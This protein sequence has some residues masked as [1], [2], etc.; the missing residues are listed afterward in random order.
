MNDVRLG[1]LETHVLQKVMELIDRLK[2]VEMVSVDLCPGIFHRPRISD[3]P[4][5]LI[6]D[7]VDDVGIFCVFEN[8]EYVGNGENNKAGQQHVVVQ[9]DQIIKKYSLLCVN[10]LEKDVF[11][12]R[13]C[14]QPDEEAAFVVL[15]KQVDQFW[16]AFRCY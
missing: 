13:E 12:P 5:V 10:E 6:K 11:Q 14:N 15:D 3:R 1:F 8:V 4:S 2:Q 9:K 7:F 16:G